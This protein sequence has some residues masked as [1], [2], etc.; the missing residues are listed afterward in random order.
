MGM[1]VQAS[2]EAQVFGANVMAMLSR[3]QIGEQAT[4][5]TVTKVLIMPSELNDNK[6]FGIAEIVKEIND[7]I[8]RI[9]NNVGSTEPVPE[10]GSYVS[11][12]DVKN[13]LNVVG[14]G[15]AVL[16]FMQTF[17]YYQGEKD[18]GQQVKTQSM[19]F[20]I[21]I[22]IKGNDYDPD[23]FKFLEIREAYINVW[24]TERQKVLERMKIWTE[25]QLDTK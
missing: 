24:N 13:A 20:A 23:G 18:A 4:G 3:E 12:E 10:T 21:G 6:P 16:T 25:Q 17:I 14:L 5:K 8:Y 19:E 22:H 9:E 15:D 2:V 11:A 1:N 7:T